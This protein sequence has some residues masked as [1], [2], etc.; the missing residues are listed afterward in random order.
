MVDLR[1][2]LVVE[3]E[4]ELRR[5]DDMVTSAVEA[6]TAARLHGRCAKNRD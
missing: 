2:L 5:R 4:G 3:D 1:R 6:A